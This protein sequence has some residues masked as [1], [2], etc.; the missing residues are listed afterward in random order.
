MSVRLKNLTAFTLAVLYG[1]VGLTGVSLHKLVDDFSLKALYSQDS[2]SV[3]YFHTH[4]PDNHPHFHHHHGDRQAES[5]IATAVDEKNQSATNLKGNDQFHSPH[6]CPLLTLVSQLKVGQG[7]WVA[8]RI[9]SDSL[10]A[11]ATESNLRP[12]FGVASLVRAR[13]PP[14]TSYLA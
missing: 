14:A 5:S 10:Q 1:L 2:G 4:Q 7:G 6:A 12:A 9:D 11:S 8:I 3:G 13:G